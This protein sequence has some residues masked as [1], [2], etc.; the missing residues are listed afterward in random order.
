MAPSFDDAYRAAAE[1]QADALRAEQTRG[2]HAEDGRSHARAVAEPALAALVEPLRRRLEASRIPMRTHTDRSRSGLFARRGR[3]FWPLAPSFRGTRET[4]NLAGWTSDGLVLTRSGHFSMDYRL[5][6]PEGFAA[7]LDGIDMADASAPSASVR[8]GGLFVDRATNLVH[9]YRAIG[10]GVEERV[11]HELSSY[12][13]DMVVRLELVEN[14]RR[15]G[16]A[17]GG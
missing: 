16:T 6:G 2:R 3:H 4:L 10:D 5:P 13:A 14:N 11:V 15:N 17:Y 9:C 1:R 8:A 7:L 12:L